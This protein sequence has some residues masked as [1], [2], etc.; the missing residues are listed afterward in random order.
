MLR[1]GCNGD[2]ECIINREFGV[3]TVH[4]SDCNKFGGGGGSY[5]FDQQPSIEFPHL[6][7]YY[8]NDN[9]GDFRP[10]SRFSLTRSETIYE[11]L[12][13]NDINLF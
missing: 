3:N 12:D 6:S 8:D 1:V 5:K 11:E 2:E 9:S 13:N 7:I 4:G 10:P